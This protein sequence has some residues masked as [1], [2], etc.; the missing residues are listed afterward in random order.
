MPREISFFDAYIPTVLL[1]AIGA[2][3]IAML[4]DRVLVR[5]GFYELTWHPALFRVSLFVC[6][7]AL[8][9]LAVYR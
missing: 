8:L 4:A 6:L 3:V 2:A 9:G 5:L 7:A 1:L